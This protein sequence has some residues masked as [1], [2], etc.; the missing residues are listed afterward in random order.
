M[1]LSPEA[2][3]DAHEAASFTSTPGDSA[4]CGSWTTHGE[5]HLETTA[6]GAFGKGHKSDINRG[7]AEGVILNGS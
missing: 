3:G 2:W 1:T 6:N 4:E 5:K 7:G